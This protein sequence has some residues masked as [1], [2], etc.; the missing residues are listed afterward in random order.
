MT[1]TVPNLT[2]PRTSR[3]LCYLHTPEKDARARLGLRPRLT[4]SGYALG[5]SPRTT[6]LVSPHTLLKATRLDQSAHAPHQ[7]NQKRQC[8]TASIQ[9]VQLCSFGSLPRA[10]VEWLRK[11]SVHLCSF[12]SLPR[13]SVGFLKI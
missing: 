5:S 8:P 7:V 13:A 9:S 11:E 1:V 2:K 10:S 3:N 12:G 4:A 6:H